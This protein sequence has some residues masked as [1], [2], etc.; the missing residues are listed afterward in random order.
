VEADLAS[1]V[2]PGRD[3][4]RRALALI[5]ID[6]DAVLAAVGADLQDDAVPRPHRRRWWSRRRKRCNQAPPSRDRAHVPFSPRAKASFELAL[7][8]ALRLGSREI[9]SEHLL[10]GILRE[11]RGL[12]CSLLTDRG[13]SVPAL[14]HDL[15]QAVRRTA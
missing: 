2:G 5:V 8:E 13:A 3:A 9:T 7:R 10:L 4:D 15:E 14:R 6:L 1:H 12:A 11:G